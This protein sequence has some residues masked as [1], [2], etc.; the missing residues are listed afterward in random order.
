MKKEMNISEYAKHAG[1]SRKT[2]HKHINSGLLAKTKSGAIDVKKADKILAILH[3]EASQENDELDQKTTPG[4]AT[5]ED[6]TYLTQKRMAEARYR[7]AKAQL[8]ELELAVRRS[9]FLKTE[10]VVSDLTFVNIGI[11]QKLLS[12]QR[13]LPGK[14]AHKDERGCMKVLQDEVY[15]I[16]SELGS[17][18]SGIVSGVKVSPG[19][20]QEEIKR[21]L[22]AK[23]PRSI[24]NKED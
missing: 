18:M 12:W 1:L 11:K 16:L 4:E 2:V 23:S 22:G 6:V 15:W 7:L 13:A 3:G 17:G 20:L 9:E 5:P 19:E 21:I 14:L 24:K 8:A 10:Q